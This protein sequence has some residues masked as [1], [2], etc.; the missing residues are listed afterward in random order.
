VVVNEAIHQGPSCTSG[1]FLNPLALGDDLWEL[2]GL[3]VEGVKELELWPGD[4]VNAGCSSHRDSASAAA[5]C[6][7]GLYYT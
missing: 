6:V 7:P 1:A 4:G 5:F 3:L 2:C